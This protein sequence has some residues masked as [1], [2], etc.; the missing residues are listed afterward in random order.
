MPPASD[1]GPRFTLTGLQTAV[2][3]LARAR[4]L[5]VPRA[6]VLGDCDP[7][8]VLVAMEAIAGG[9]LAGAWPHDDGAGVLTAIGLA[10]ADLEAGVPGGC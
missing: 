5:E 6:E 9:V 10:A 1:A 4:A 8:N 2:A 3:L 7:A